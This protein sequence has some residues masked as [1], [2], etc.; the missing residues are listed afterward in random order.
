MPNI[1]L[2]VYID[3]GGNFDFSPSGTKYYSLTCL[4][5]HHPEILCE[6][7]NNKRNRI[8]SGQELSK[9]GAEYLENHLAMRFH[10]S[11]DKQP[12]R[13]EVFNLIKKVQPGVIKSHSIIAQKN[14]ANPSIRGQVEFYSKLVVPILK[15][16]LKGYE[17]SVLIIFLDNSPVNKQKE[18]LIKNIKQTI[19]NEFPGKTYAIYCVPS[20]SNHLLQVSDYINWAIFRKWEKGDDRSYVL[21]KDYLEKPE[22]DIFQKGLTTYY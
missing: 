5:T 10:A 14:K 2:F 12:V 18:A 1:P 16:A 7:L 22:L 4:A 15:F 17:S 19:S 3:E 13:D 9:L 8:L 6:E 20:E 21:I 11:E